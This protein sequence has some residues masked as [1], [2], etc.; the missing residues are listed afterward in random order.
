MLKTGPKRSK[1]ERQ[2]RLHV[3]AEMHNRGYSQ[4]AIAA[5]LGDPTSTQVEYDLKVLKKRYQNLQQLAVT[6]HRE[7]ISDQYRAIFEEMWE[8]YRESKTKKVIA[9]EKVTEGTAVI[10]TPVVVEVSVNP[11]PR[12]MGIAKGCL[13]AFRK[14]IGADL[15]KGA[16]PI[17]NN[18]Q[19]VQVDWEP[20]ATQG[21]NEVDSKLEDL[22]QLPDKPQIGLKELPKGATGNGSVE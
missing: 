10:S 17:I 6:A 22:E 2:Q 20:T 19:V 5:Q 15:D 11:D 8:A 9:D 1:L 13:E 3:V 14:L 16:A 12:F 4:K 21:V 18:Q 7:E